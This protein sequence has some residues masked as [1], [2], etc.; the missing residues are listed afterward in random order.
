LF[1]KRKSEQKTGQ[2][3]SSFSNGNFNQENTSFGSK[4]GNVNA[5]RGSVK[6]GEGFLDL[7]ENF[8]ISYNFNLEFEPSI[9]TGRDTLVVTN[10]SIETRG[11][12]NSNWL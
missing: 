12:I 11:N 6:S 4:Q 5:S 2:G 7:F 3:A 9:A 8:R 1:G 10:H